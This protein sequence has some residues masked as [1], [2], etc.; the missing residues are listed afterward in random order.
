MKEY[1]SLDLASY[2]S[3][4]IFIFWRVQRVSLI[5]IIAVSLQ[6]VQTNHQS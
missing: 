5:V 4:A 2:L 3:S 6:T 1:F